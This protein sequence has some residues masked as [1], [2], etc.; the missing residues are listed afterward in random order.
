MAFEHATD[1]ADGIDTAFDAID[2]IGAVEGSDENFGLLQS[3]LLC[4]VEPYL[5]RGSGGVSVN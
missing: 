3:E 1:L 2:K 4:D 5:W